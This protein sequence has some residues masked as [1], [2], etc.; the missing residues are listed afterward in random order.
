MIENTL[1]SVRSKLRNL[2]RCSDPAD[3]SSE[4]WKDAPIRRSKLRNLERC[5]DSPI[6]APKPGKMLR[7][8]DRSSET[9]KDAPIRRSKLRNLEGCSDPLIEAPEFGTSLRSVRCEVRN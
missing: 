9:W 2:E 4:T 6:E 8:A 1:R 7:F 5:S 3:R